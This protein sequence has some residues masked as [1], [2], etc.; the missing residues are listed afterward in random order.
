[1]YF[2]SI[3]ENRRVKPVKTVRRRGEGERGRMMEK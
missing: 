3:Y 2:A 1:M